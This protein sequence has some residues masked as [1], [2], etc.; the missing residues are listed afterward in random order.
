VNEA[1]ITKLDCDLLYLEYTTQHV[2]LNAYVEKW[3]KRADCNLIPPAHFKIIFQTFSTTTSSLASAVGTG[4]AVATVAA[5]AVAGLAHEIVLA[6]ASFFES[7]P[8]KD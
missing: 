8:N 1:L 4:V 5:V 7:E 6:V 3:A 2:L